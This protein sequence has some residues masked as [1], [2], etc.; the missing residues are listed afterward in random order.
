MKNVF[1]YVKY[2]MQKATNLDN[3][4]DGNMKLQKLLTFSN[5]INMTLNNE[6]LFN[7]NLYAFKNGCVV[8]PV[9]LKYINEYYKLKQDSNNFKP[10]FSNS[11]FEVLNIT[12]GIFDKLSATEL[13]DLNHEFDFWKKSYDPKK[14][15]CIVS[16]ESIQN[17]LYIIKDMIES[18]KNRDKSNK[19]KVINGITF[20]YNPSNLDI[21]GSFVVDGKSFNI[22]D[23]LYDF[24]LSDEVDEDCYSIYLDESGE[25]VI[26]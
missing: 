2:F 11:E 13:S 24:T 23:E 4:K 3:S 16:N 18:Y 26:F 1:D 25:L 15:Y 17:E 22:M 19:S 9:R 8:E 10:N 20:Y 5:L 12:L 14:R 6:P 7:E 21:N